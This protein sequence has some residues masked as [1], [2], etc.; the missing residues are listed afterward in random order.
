L[1]VGRRGLVRVAVE[2]SESVLGELSGD[3]RLSLGC[4]YAE[5]EQAASEENRES[6][7]RL[8]GFILRCLD[9]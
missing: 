6:E 5:H 4:G 7:S 3:R 8:H 2:T 9:R 1:L